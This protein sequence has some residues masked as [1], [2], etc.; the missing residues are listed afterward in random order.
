MSIIFFY[1]LDRNN[2][3]DR[4]RGLPQNLLQAQRAHG[5]RAGTLVDSANLL[6]PF[7]GWSCCSGGFLCSHEVQVS[8]TSRRTGRSNLLD[9]W[10]VQQ[11]NLA[12]QLPHLTSG[13]GWSGCRPQAVSYSPPNS[14]ISATPATAGRERTRASDCPCRAKFGR[15]GM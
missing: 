11:V 2:Q 15:I 5:S 4:S 1:R 3:F 10:Q 13:S 6:Q 12:G 8:F 9:S 14:S 7:P